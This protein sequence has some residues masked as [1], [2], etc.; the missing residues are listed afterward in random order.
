GFFRSFFEPLDNSTPNP[1]PATV[2]MLSQFLGF[3]TYLYILCLGS[4]CLLGLFPSTLAY[5]SK[6]IRVWR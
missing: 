2:S 4:A 3:Q 6:K 5:H 1:Y